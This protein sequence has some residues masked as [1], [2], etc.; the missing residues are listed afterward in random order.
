MINRK[1][2]QGSD[3]ENFLQKPGIEPDE[4][5]ERTKTSV[6]RPRIL[7]HE[8]TDAHRHDQDALA[9]R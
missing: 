5:G 6:K 2:L 4:R 1:Y 8:R 9:D 3:Q 7:R